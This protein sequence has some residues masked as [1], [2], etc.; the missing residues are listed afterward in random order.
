MQ[1]GAGAMSFIN[2]NTTGDQISGMGKAA[3]GAV[4]MLPVPGAQLAGKS[5]ELFAKVLGGTIDTLQQWGRSIRDANFRFAEFS[6]SMAQVQAE[7]EMRQVQLDRERGDRRAPWAKE[8]VEAADRFDR[9][10]APLSDALDKISTKIKTW[11]LNGS[12]SI[13][14]AITGK[15]NASKDEKSGFKFLGDN[16]FREIADLMGGTMFNDQKDRPDWLK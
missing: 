12:A 13:V 5:L 4:S 9:A 8:G 3:G 16:A 1:S 2:A 7:H 11:I 6:S 10:I 15:G 14:Q